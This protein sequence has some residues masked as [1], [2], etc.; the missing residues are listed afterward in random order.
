LKNGFAQQLK[1]ANPKKARRSK[2]SI[3]NLDFIPMDK[4]TPDLQLNA[5]E[6]GRLFVATTGVELAD[7]AS[8]I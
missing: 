8:E 6:E 4:Q 2:R 3:L 5:A 7:I 1:S